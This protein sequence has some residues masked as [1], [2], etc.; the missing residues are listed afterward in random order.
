MIKTG[1]TRFAI[2]KEALISK[3]ETFFYA[4]IASGKWN[5]GQDGMYIIIIIILLLW[6]F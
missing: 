1:G 3:K 2:S 5:P 4:M 6:C